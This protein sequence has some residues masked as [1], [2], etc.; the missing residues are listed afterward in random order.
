ML[1]YPPQRVFEVAP[2]VPGFLSLD[3]KPHSPGG[4]RR[5]EEFRFKIFEFR[6]SGRSRSSI[7]NRKSTFEN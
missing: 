6:L 1:I 7:A 2:L 3:V 5:L 4:T